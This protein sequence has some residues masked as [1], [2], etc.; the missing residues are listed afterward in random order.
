MDPRL[1]LRISLGLIVAVAIAFSPVLICDFIVLDDYLYVVANPHVRSGLSWTNFV[2]AWTAYHAYYWHPLTWLSHMLDCQLFGLNARGHHLVNLLFHLANTA[3]LFVVLRRMTGDLWRP[4][5]AAALFGLHPLRVESVAWIAERKDVLSTFLAILTLGAYTAYAARPGVG[6]YLAVLLFFALGLLAKPMLVTLPFALLLLDYWP[7]RSCPISPATPNDTP[8]F[9]RAGWGWL[10]A[11]KVPLLALTLVISV[12]TLRTQGQAMMSA[13]ALPLGVRLD[14]AV[15]SYAAYLRKTVWPTDLAAFYQHPLGG[16]PSAQVLAAAAVLVALTILALALGRRRPAVIVGWLWFLG[17]LVPVSGLAQ[18][19]G[20]AMADRFSY[21][22]HIGLFM[23]VVWAIPEWPAARA[24]IGAAALLV[25]GAYIVL[26]WRQ[27]LT[28]RNDETLWQQAFRV[29]DGP[30][31]HRIWANTLYSTGRVDRAEE[32]YRAA[33]RLQPD[34]TPALLDL[35]DCQ[36]HRGEIDPALGTFVMGTA[37]APRSSAMHS[38]LG[39]VWICKGRIDRAIAAFREAC[40]LRPD[41]AEYHY[42]LAAALAR[43]GDASEAQREYEEGRRLNPAWPEWAWKQA[44]LLLGEDKTKYNCP[45]EALFRAEQACHGSVQPS[46]RMRQTL[47]DA[48]K[49]FAGEPKIGD[50]LP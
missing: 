49:A 42:N 31:V 45:A 13:E 17:T 28:W 10:V 41:I 3:G 37:V 22:P 6:R 16:L 34:F 29:A 1:P 11:E 50:L 38:G 40:R 21:L 19:G 20:Q 46:P 24:W 9:A 35:G 43:S 4:A 25:L 15:A 39:R 2:W 12:L 48:R 32:E 14:N 18:A 8:T 23:A 33:L 5:L 7:L 30:A 47:A 26:T 44:T 27:A 36:L